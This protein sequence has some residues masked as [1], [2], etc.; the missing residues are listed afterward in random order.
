MRF[1]LNLLT[2]IEWTPVQV[3]G[4][5]GFDLAGPA[6]Q[7]D[8]LRVG[9]DVEGKLAE[10]IDSLSLNVTTTRCLFCKKSALAGR[11][12]MPAGAR[13]AGPVR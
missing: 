12:F 3:L 5:F 2:R 1:W 11:R 7:Q 10:G 8:W 13:Y 4:L 9:A 6:N